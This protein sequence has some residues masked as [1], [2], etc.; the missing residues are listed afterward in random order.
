[1]RWF[2]HWLCSHRRHKLHFMEQRVPRDIE[3]DPTGV[4][5][6]WNV[7]V[8]ERCQTEKTLRTTVRA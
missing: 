1:M 4:V 2:G 3:P 5:I 7:Y 8:C 6:G